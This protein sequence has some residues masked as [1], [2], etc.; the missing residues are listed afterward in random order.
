MLIVLRE[1]KSRISA[2]ELLRRVS[3]IYDKCHGDEY[4]Q[5]KVT[6]ARPK[7][8]ILHVKV[9]LLDEVLVDIESGRVSAQ[10]YGGH[11]ERG[12]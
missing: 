1:S 7:Q 4:W 6:T 5:V 2:A 10:P 12:I 11:T 9:V 8:D 3:D